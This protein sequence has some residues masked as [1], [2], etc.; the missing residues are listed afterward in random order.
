MYSM[1]TPL[2]VAACALFFIKAGEEEGAFF[3]VLYPFLSLGLSALAI[4]VFKFG[5]I[6]LVVLQIGLF[7][8]ITAWRGIA[9]KN[10]H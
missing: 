5:V 3:R 6:G 10:I 9:K 1:F 2:F 7:A 8:A 4:L